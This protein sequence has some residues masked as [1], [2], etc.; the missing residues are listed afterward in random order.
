MGLLPHH[1]VELNL[2][3]TQ[4]G[5]IGCAVGAPF[6]VLVA[7]QLAVSGCEL[8]ISV[9]SSGS[10]TP[11]ADPPYFVIIDRALRDEGTSH[12]YL[13]PGQWAAAPTRLLG[14]LDGRL[15]G[16][17]QPVVT[18]STWT[19]DALYRETPDAIARAEQLGIVAVEMEAAALDA[20]AAVHHRQPDRSHQTAQCGWPWWMSGRC[21]CSWSSRSWWCRCV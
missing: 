5:V 8:V 19:T 4:V 1:T 6:A 12:H 3:G 16:L 20:V 7:E 17:T 15:S 11:V 21:G 13:P 2:D 14:K 10:I 9:T 18:G